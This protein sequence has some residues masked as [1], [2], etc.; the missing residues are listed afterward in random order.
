MRPKPAIVAFV[1]GQLQMHMKEA[2]GGQKSGITKAE[3]CFMQ[4]QLL[5]SLF[6]G[7]SNN[8]QSLRTPIPRSLDTACESTDQRKISS[9][10]SANM[11]AA[12]AWFD[13]HYDDSDGTVVIGTCNLH[14]QAPVTITTDELPERTAV[15]CHL[16]ADT[17][18]HHFYSI[19]V[20]PELH[21]LNGGKRPP[22]KLI[23]STVLGWKEFRQALDVEG[24]DSVPNQDGIESGSSASFKTARSRGNSAG[25]SASAS[26]A[27]GS[28][29]TISVTSPAAKPHGDDESS[30]VT[31]ALKG[32][33]LKKS[34]K[35]SKREKDSNP[36]G[37]IE[38]DVAFVNEPSPGNPSGVSKSSPGED[39]ELIHTI[40]L[41]MA[42]FRMTR[43][44]NRVTAAGLKHLGT[45]LVRYGFAIGVN[46]PL[47]M[48]AWCDGDGT[49]FVKA[50]TPV[51]AL[52]WNDG[53]FESVL[54][55][56]VS[57]ILG[58]LLVSQASLQQL[59]SVMT[60]MTGAP[61]KDIGVPYPSPIHAA[62]QRN[63]E[64]AARLRQE[65]E[66]KKPIVGDVCP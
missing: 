31:D 33:G 35:P 28:T 20:A 13:A 16:D 8:K 64:K 22:L 7:R 1:S 48:N 61:K 52:C 53:L 50:L 17:T 3:Q 59:R 24:G 15:A 42:K 32:L 36:M 30:Q 29:F 26:T 27:R 39:G 66:G 57:D 23:K 12:N 25:S 4:V 38:L 37:K 47:L 46:Y 2:D 14:S 45:N 10:R 11:D 40:V 49:A 55:K 54:G 62:V 18:T 65:S 63:I 9:P 56:E 34:K 51:I 41:W 21:V 58:V 44:F 5:D 60:R 6:P 43:S 19:K